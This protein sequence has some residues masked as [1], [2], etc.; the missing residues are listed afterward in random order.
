MEETTELQ[1]EEKK[2]GTVKK[3]ATK[4]RREKKEK[5]E[6]REKRTKKNQNNYKKTNHDYL[7]MIQ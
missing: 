6:I 4:S 7:F 5:K 2:R 1:T 3:Q